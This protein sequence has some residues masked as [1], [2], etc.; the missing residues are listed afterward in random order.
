MSF[1]YRSKPTRTPRGVVVGTFVIGLLLTVGC[2]LLVL[3]PLFT[4]NSDHPHDVDQPLN[5]W[6][7]TGL[8]LGLILI[9]AGVA[10]L[11]LNARVRK[12][13]NE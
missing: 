13:E 2:G 9:I 5:F 11:V 1:D 10:A 8:I 4:T 3:V 12:L 7:M 6:G